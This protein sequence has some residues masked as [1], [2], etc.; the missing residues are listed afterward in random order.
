MSFLGS[1]GEWI[2]RNPG[3]AAGAFAGFLF[4]VL[5]FTIGVL[6]TILILIFVL[7]GYIIGKSRDDNLS[8]VEE[9]NELFRGKR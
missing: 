7:I 9:I 2:S 5:L 8:I 4:G 6:K 3:R 1:A